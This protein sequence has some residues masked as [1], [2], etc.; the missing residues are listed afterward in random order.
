M[1]AQN[2]RELAKKA[3]N[4]LLPLVFDEIKKSAEKGKFQCFFYKLLS[5]SEIDELVNLGYKVTQ[6]TDRD[7]ILVTVDWL[8][9]NSLRQI[10]PETPVDEPQ[11][12]M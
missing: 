9:N 12:R 7:G 4:K 11:I 5:T 3:N 2:A 10:Y 8:P 1:N 6:G